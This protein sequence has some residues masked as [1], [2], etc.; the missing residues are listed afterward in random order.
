MCCSLIYL[1]MSNKEFQREK[2]LRFLPFLVRF[3]NCIFAKI[4]FND[5]CDYMNLNRKLYTLT[6]GYSSLYIGCTL[7]NKY[8]S[9]KMPFIILKWYY[10]FFNGNT[11]ANK[12]LGKC[13]YFCCILDLS[14]FYFN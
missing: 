1:S 9:E 7:T 6:S 3:F 8:M 2:V 12:L 13:N 14:A 5:E 4:V 11:Y 10:S